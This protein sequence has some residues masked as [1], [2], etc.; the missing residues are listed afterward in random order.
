ME[1]DT[2]IKP[3]GQIIP[4]DTDK[5]DFVG[6]V[7][8]DEYL[9]QQAIKLGTVETGAFNGYGAVVLKD[10]EF[11]NGIIEFDIAFDQ[12]QMYTGLHFRLK[13][14]QNCESF[15]MRPHVSGT[16]DANS[17]I[18]VYHDV[19]SWQLY[20]GKTFSTA[21]KY[22]FTEW[23]HIKIIINDDVA[24]I[25]INDMQNPQNTVALKHDNKSGKVE[26]YTLNFGGTTRFANFA[27][28]Q[29]DTQEI[30]GMPKEEPIAQT[31][32]I[33][34]WEISESFDEKIL[35]GK[36]ILDE[37]IRNLNYTTIK[38]DITGITNL[39]K[40]Q[41][42]QEGKDTAFAKITIHSDIDQ[43]KKMDFGFANKVKV[44]LNG[45]ILFEGDDNFQS[46]DETFLGT[47]G[48]YDSVYLHF[49]KGTN[50]VLL[51]ITEHALFKGGW[52]VKARFENVDGIIIPEI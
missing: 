11:H 38:S 40:V 46:R 42:V 21:S 10:T 20:Y 51:A 45:A 12:K 23:N 9:G 13:G 2:I 43:I 41:G 15:Y 8:K 33:L 39:A 37:N 4:F 24:D 29:T 35:L 17:Y 34:N 50:E 3:K 19:Q 30:K 6:K 28:L 31:G 27:L 26:L 22:S 1:N 25:F 5:W 14:N 48:L 47:M 16:P 32:S 7:E 36:T 49:K 44:Y 52:G 18:P